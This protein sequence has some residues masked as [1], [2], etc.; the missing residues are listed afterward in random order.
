MLWVDPF[1][2]SAVQ[3]QRRLQL[4]RQ[5][6]IVAFWYEMSHFDIRFR[7]EMEKSMLKSGKSFSR[8]HDAL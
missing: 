5:R 4:G 1:F 7:L 2:G 3:P 8:N 6:V